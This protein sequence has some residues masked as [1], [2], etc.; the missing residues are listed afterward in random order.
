VF[1]PVSQLDK[2][3]P[4][5]LYPRRWIAEGQR[6]PSA[7]ALSYFAAVPRRWNIGPSDPYPAPVVAVDEGRKR[8]LSAYEGRGF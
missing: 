3:D 5:H 1:N 6:T 8:A 4:D 7:T 2:F